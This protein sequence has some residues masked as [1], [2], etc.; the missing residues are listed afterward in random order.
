MFNFKKSFHNE[1]TDAM[2]QL[3]DISENIKKE[4][5]CSLHDFDA[6]IKHNRVEKWKCKNCSCVED[7]NFVDAYYKGLE[8][9]RKQYNE[10]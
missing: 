4:K 1:Y 9:G 10:D 3:A 8:H 2:N 6:I 5:S 7:G